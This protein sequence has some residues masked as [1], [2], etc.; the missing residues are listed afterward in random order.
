MQAHILCLADWFLCEEYRKLAVAAIE[1]DSTEHEQL[2]PVLGTCPLCRAELRW[3]DLISEMNKRARQNLVD[4]IKGKATKKVL[5]P[6]NTKSYTRQH[7]KDDTL[8]SL[9]QSY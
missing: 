3:G 8:Q 5:G 4:S 9:T 7:V 1:E 6:S 2:V